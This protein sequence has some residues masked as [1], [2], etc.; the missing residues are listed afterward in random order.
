MLGN[1]MD[2]SSYR[3]IEGNNWVDLTPALPFSVNTFYDIA[4]AGDTVYVATDAG[5][6]TTDD[7]RSWQTITGKD[8]LNL[9]MDHL[10]AD[11]TTLYGI[12]K[13]HRYLSLGERHMGTGCFRCS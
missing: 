5:I 12:R 3:M 13:K 2:I 6:I 8:G 11:G 4:V 1:E 7:G 9:I 10:T